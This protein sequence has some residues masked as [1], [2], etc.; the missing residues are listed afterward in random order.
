MDSVE[1]H[2][3]I[4][5][6]LALA[7]IEYGHTTQRQLR[8]ARKTIGHLTAE[9]RRLRHQLTRRRVCNETAHKLGR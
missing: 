4:S 1:Q 5:F 8:D 7:A 3:G 6:A 2:G 9:D